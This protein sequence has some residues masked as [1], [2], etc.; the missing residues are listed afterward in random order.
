MT[1]PSVA[2]TDRGWT[3]DDSTFGARL[4]LIRQRMDWNIKE[5]G[6]QTGIAPSTW[7]EW[8]RKGREPS[9]ILASVRQIADRTGCDYFWLLTGER[10]VAA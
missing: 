10:V 1:Q 7:T 9:S 3:V 6:D 5:A 2:T 4:A 8:E